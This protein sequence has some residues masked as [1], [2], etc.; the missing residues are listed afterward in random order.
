MSSQH[1]EEQV[2][3]AVIF[4]SQF[5][6]LKVVFIGNEYLFIFKTWPE[7]LSQE[8]STKIGISKGNVPSF[9]SWNS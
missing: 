2:V 3:E 4:K 8:H 7:E 5:H 1:S 9:Q 6:S